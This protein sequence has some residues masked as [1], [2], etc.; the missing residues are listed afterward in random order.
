MGSW[1]VA[2]PLYISAI[3]SGTFGYTGKDNWSANVSVLVFSLL[4]MFVGLWYIYKRYNRGQTIMAAVLFICALVLLIL[5]CCELGMGQPVD[6]GYYFATIFFAVIGLIF[7]V[8]GPSPF[9][10]SAAAAEA[11]PPPSAADD[12]EQVE[13]TPVMAS[14]PAD[15]MPMSKDTVSATGADGDASDVGPD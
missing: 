11:V 8:P 4:S 10:R 5:S 3:V 6:T 2:L 12:T 15:D 1:I 14:A 9:S 7:G 13:Q